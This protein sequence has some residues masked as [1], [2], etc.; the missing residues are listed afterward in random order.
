LQRN[1]LYRFPWSQVDNPGTWIEVTD[2]CD[3]FCPGCFRHRL[4]GHRPLE[5]IKDEV[6]MSQRS[7]NCE[8]VAIAGGEPLIYPHLLDVVDFI[9]KQGMKPALMTNGERL[10]REYAF[11]LK[12]A[13]LAQFYF[14][15]DSGQQRPGWE[16]KDEIEANQLRQHYADMVSELKG[17][18]CGYNITMT[19]TNLGALPEIIRWGLANIDKVNSLSLIAMRG[20]LVSEGIEYQAGNESVDVGRIQC[21]ADSTREIDITSDE[22]FELVQRMNPDLRPCAF[23]NGTVDSSTNKFLVI[24]PIGCRG[25]SYGVCGPR[26]IELFQILHHFFTGR[27]TSLVRT[28]RPSKIIFLL[29]ALDREIRKAFRRFLK[30]SVHHPSKL[31][32]KVHLQC[33]NLVQPTELIDDEKNFCDGCINLIPWNGKMVHSCVLDEYRIFGEPIKPVRYQKP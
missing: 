29:S 2:S 26:S 22:M 23:L 27:Y 11:E 30:A 24:I 19:R 14:H 12:K 25:G 9:A 6:L 21:S 15:V 7:T 17:V 13:G 5:V 20:L 28:P 16:G 18:K 4:E 32:R 31:F 8:R 3:L 33:I 10:T 1:S